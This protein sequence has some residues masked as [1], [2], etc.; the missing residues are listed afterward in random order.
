M[1]QPMIIASYDD[2]HKKRPDKTKVAYLTGGTKG[3]VPKS[4]GCYKLVKIIAR[5]VIQGVC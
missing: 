3:W 5:F 2:G 4:K 1:A